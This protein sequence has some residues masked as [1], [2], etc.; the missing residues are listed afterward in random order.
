VS[1]NTE[2]VN[3]SLEKFR[4]Y[5]ETLTFIQ[6]DPRLRGKVGRSDLIQ[7]T[8]IEASRTPERIGAMDSESQK[9]WLRCMLLNNLRDEID[10]WLTKGHD[11][12]REQSL[13]EAAGSG[14]WP[15]CPPCQS[16]AFSRFIGHARRYPLGRKHLRFDTRV[17]RYARTDMRACGDAA[18]R[19]Q[20]SH[21]ECGM[22]VVRHS[23]IPDYR[24]RFSG[25][26]L[27]VHGGTREGAGG[28]RPR[29]GRSARLSIHQYTMRIGQG[30]A[31]LDGERLRRHFSPRVSHGGGGGG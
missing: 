12:G 18:T 27:G 20:T 31:A 2:D 15:K 14:E 23:V 17:L 13:D 29:A 1:S 28:A 6:V 7:K 24:S 5:L 4:A 22:R 11:V 19:T 3:R 10:H 21:C 26:G 25:E 9:R 8:L 30:R 16:L